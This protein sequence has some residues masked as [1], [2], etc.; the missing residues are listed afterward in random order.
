MDMLQSLLQSESF[1]VAVSTVLCIGF[2]AFK[3][4]RPLLASLDARA[5]SIRVRLA[6]AETLHEEAKAVLEEYKT[7]SASAF[8]EAEQV[9]RNAQARADKMRTEMEKEMAETI[10]RQEAGLKMRLARLEAEAIE[11]VKQTLIA[12]AIAQVQTSVAND[13]AAVGNLDKSLNRISKT[14]N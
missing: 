14:I 8:K 2:I 7:K 10:A 12:D 9:L 11:T 5:D 4:Y 3:A 13:G 1:W 6:E